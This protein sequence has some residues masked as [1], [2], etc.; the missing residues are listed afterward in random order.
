MHIL[1]WIAALAAVAS[2]R[3]AETFAEDL[4]VEPLADGKVLQHYEFTVE[5]EAADAG[6]QHNYRLF[7]RQLG[8]IARRYGVRELQLALRQGGW[9]DQW[10]YAPTAA[11]GSAGAELVT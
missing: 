10:G 5:R 4:L 6:D 7:P 3:P 11:Q 1:L 2:G 9:R 8:E